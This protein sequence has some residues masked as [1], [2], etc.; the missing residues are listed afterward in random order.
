[1]PSGSPDA[2]SDKNRW[3]DPSLRTAQYLT[4]EIAVARAR[5]AHALANAGVTDKDVVRGPSLLSVQ[6][7]ISKESSGSEAV[8]LTFPAALSAARLPIDFPTWAEEPAVRERCR[9]VGEGNFTA[10]KIALCT[11]APEPQVRGSVEYIADLAEVSF[12]VMQKQDF[13]SWF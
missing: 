2:F 7:S 8:D 11:L 12:T 9:A 5:A 4:N 3:H 1:M 6:C 13:R 10:G